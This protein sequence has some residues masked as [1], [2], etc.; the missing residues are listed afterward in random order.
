[1]PRRLPAA[2]SEDPHTTLAALVHHALELGV[3]EASRRFA[4]A[5]HAT[6]G[7]ND[8][9]RVTHMVDGLMEA[10]KADQPVLNQ[11]IKE[12]WS[13]GGNAERR[14]A[15][16][17]V[18]TTLRPLVP[19]RALTLAR[20]LAAMASTDHETKLVSEEA[21]APLLRENPALRERVRPF[22]ADPNPSV[23][24]SVGLSLVASLDGGKADVPVV[25]SFLLDLALN[26]ADA[27]LL[28]SLLRE[29]A[30]IDANAVGRGLAEWSTGARAREAPARAL[31]QALRI[32]VQW[33]AATVPVV[34]ATSR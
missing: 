13:R 16:R 18:G 30:Q 24:R 29:L 31:A 27:P 9:G 33:P 26:E 19:H 23:R 4:G 8:A 10:V 1:M 20:E 22:L 34:P 21:L 14:V 6:P 11:I 32:K 12:V 7:G 28:R 5:E 17:A 25:T 2:R 15:A 3:G